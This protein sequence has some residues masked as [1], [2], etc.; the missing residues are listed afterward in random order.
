MYLV[1]VISINRTGSES[2]AVGHHTGWKI[3][4]WDNVEMPELFK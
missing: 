3:N 4:H 1:D 2:V